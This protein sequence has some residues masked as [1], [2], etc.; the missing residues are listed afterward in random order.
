MIESV[1]KTSCREHGKT[2]SRSLLNSLFC[3]TIVAAIL[4]CCIRREEPAAF[5]KDA[6]AELEADFSDA[7]ALER[8]ANLAEPN[9]PPGTPIHSKNRSSI[10]WIVENGA[11]VK[12]GDELVKLETA[13]LEKSVAELT[14]ESHITRAALVRAEAT[15]AVTEIALVEFTEGLFPL[16]EEEVQVELL[17][18]EL[19]SAHAEATGR[20]AEIYEAKVDRRTQRCHRCGESGNAG[21]RGTRPSRQEPPRPGSGATEIVLDQSSDI[22]HGF[23]ECAAAWIG[24]SH[25]LGAAL[26]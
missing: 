7:E 12:K 13:Q 18:A 24:R 14:A 5:T 8:A 26:P 4:P 10:Q 20:P 16:Q 22:R 9:P 25:R 6:P 19:A 21:T 23:S 3:L 2:M 15:V 1:Y 17:E 11:S